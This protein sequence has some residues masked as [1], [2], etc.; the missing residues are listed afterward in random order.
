M[1]V[2]V[3]T[4]HMPTSVQTRHK[5]VTHFLWEISQRDTGSMTQTSEDLPVT[6][7]VESFPVTQVVEP[8][9]VEQI[10]PTKSD[11]YEARPRAC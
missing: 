11:T 5:P 10:I 6:Q 4:R 1:L 3:Q 9:S 2:P 7:R 8:L